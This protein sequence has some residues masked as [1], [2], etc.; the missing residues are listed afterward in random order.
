M[1]IRNISYGSCAVAAFASHIPRP[2][3]A[4]LP[5]PQFLAQRIDLGAKLDGSLDGFVPLR[6]QALVFLAIRR[7][8]RGEL[9][10]PRGR[11]LAFP[12]L[13][14]DTV[15]R[16]SMPVTPFQNSCVE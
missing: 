3:L 15:N 5:E 1:V 14:A 9:L 16:F 13:H 10:C 7:E 11:Y 4:P 2:P 8:P 6:A 12:R